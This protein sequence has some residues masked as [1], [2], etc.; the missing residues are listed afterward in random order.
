MKIKIREDLN[1]DKLYGDID[2]IIKYLESLKSKGKEVRLTWEGGYDNFWPVL[3]YEREETD[4]EKLDRIKKEKER[5]AKEDKLK[6]IKKENLI[7]E[8]KKLGLKVI[9]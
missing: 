9:E 2:E 7:K 5:K 1:Q 3:L 8:A 4:Q 6:E